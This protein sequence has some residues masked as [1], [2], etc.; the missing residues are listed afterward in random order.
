M[1]AEILMPA[2]SPSMTEGGIA[3]WLKREGDPVKAGEPLVEIETDKAVVEYE[4]QGDGIL[5]RILVPDGSPNVKVDQVIALLFQP[6]EDPAA[7]AEQRG[8]AAKAAQSPRPV[9]AATPID[10][11]PLTP[12]VTP[13]SPG[14]AALR[15][16]A[17]ESSR[18]ILA[19]PLA[20]RLAA[21]RN[22]D[23]AAL[24]GSGPN[25]RIVRLDVESAPARS[26]TVVPP[27]GATYQS[28][29]N[30]T[31]RRMI[32]Q[33]LTEAKQTIPHFY[34]G[35]DCDID[36]LLDMRRELNGWADG[37]KLSVNDF[38][39]KAV[40][41]AMKQVPGVNASWSEAA[42]L[43]HQS[44]DIS[45][46]VSTPSGLVTPIIRDADLKS[47]SQISGAMKELAERGRQGR[48]EAQEYQ[49][50]GFTISNLGMYGIREFA[51]IINP[52]QSCILA[53]GAGE[54]R[55]VVRD[56]ALAVATVMSCTLSADH[57]VVDGALGA[58]FLAAFRKLVEH[59]LT[60][61]L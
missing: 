15:P 53:V 31:M 25:G 24:K 23:L 59:P 48:L 57:R 44:V 37:V 56:G 58:E 12:A 45:V 34:L 41:L 40:A 52:P 39:I 42:I 55:P 16:A 30:N 10:L 26:A 14:A 50:G 35:I 28:I 1:P 33:R 21:A 22:V 47:L 3:R 51:A 11:P 60:M 38:I 7:V 4:A 19:S 6:G 18:R 29:P 9:T 8:S 49:G 5:G 13:V 36:A 17:L 43:R 61:L 46:A 32:A 20:R 27:A 54:Q 2:V